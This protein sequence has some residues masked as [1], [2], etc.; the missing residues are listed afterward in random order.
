MT[1]QVTRTF[2]R[3]FRRLE[4]LGLL[5]LSGHGFP[6]VAGL[7]AREKIKGSWWAHPDA[8]T[9][10][11]VAELLDDHRDVLFLKLLDGKVTLVHRQLW[12]RIFSIGV[13]REDW[14]VKALTPA[15]KL[16]LK[17]IDVEGALETGVIGKRFDS[18]QG[19]AARELEFYMLIHSSQVHTQ[20]GAHAKTLETWDHWAKSVDFRGRANNASAA[21]RFV[22]ERVESIVA[23]HGGATAPR[24]PWPPN[25]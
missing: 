18:K 16:L 20:S 9:I 7:I 21:R 24:F 8:Q 15:A 5:L 4:T 6:S 3:V 14:Q 11:E 1:G 10:F 19:T 17:K 22:V 13:A 12:S 23:E 25:A 2:D